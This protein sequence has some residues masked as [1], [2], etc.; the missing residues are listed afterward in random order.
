MMN[1]YS[2]LELLGA[3]ALCVGVGYCARWFQESHDKRVAANAVKAAN[4]AQACAA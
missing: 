3:F 4:P 1:V 2:P